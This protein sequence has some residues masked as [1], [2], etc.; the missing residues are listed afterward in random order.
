MRR[1]SIGHDAVSFPD[2]T[3]W[4]NRGV[5]IYTDVILRSPAFSHNFLPQRIYVDSVLAHFA[6]QACLLPSM[7]K[8][9]LQKLAD[10]AG[11]ILGDQDEL[12]SP[13]PKASGETVLKTPMKPVKSH[14]ELN[15]SLSKSKSANKSAKRKWTEALIENENHTLTGLREEVA[16][17]GQDIEALAQADAPLR[18]RR[19]RPKASQNKRSP[20][21]EGD[22][23]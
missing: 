6:C 8:A 20:P 11:E 4:G 3:S 15:G 2:L 7:R 14:K 17:S 1:R 13:T 22:L 21:P 9:S 18:K 16:E 5:C 19:G 12:E 10:P 23:P